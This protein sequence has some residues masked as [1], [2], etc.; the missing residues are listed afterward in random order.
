MSNRRKT[1]P[2]LVILICALS[3]VLA[4]V[5]VL[6]LMGYRYVTDNGNKFIGKVS[7]GQP[8][9]SLFMKDSEGNSVT[10]RMKNG[11]ATLSYANGDKYVG[12]IDG[13]C[14]DGEG[15]L[16]CKNGDI[17]TG[18]W[19]NDKPH[20]NGTYTYAVG[21]TYRGEIKNGVWEGTGE[22]VWSNGDRY[23]GEFKEGLA[24]GIGEYK[25]ANGNLYYGSFAKGARNG[26]GTFTMASGESY[27][28]NWVD[29]RRD[30]LGGEAVLMYA[31]GDKYTGAFIA[32]LPDTRKRDENGE[33]I[34]DE[35][36]NYVHIDV[37][38]IYTYASERFYI[39]YFE[40]GK[41]VMNDDNPVP[42]TPTVPNEE[43]T[44]TSKE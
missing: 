35:N 2:L 8:Y 42:T 27:E 20:G 16:T 12:E 9:H 4:T 7:G 31:N 14:R 38:A 3:L 44:E 15:T 40:A 32:N 28:G 5:I 34:I 25:W 30:T 33:F 23:T 18:S 6:L 39:G 10:L 13:L 26:M 19:K 43:S 21:D 37:R 17:Y 29:D 22:Y 24:D 1:N 11:V 41:I 36:G